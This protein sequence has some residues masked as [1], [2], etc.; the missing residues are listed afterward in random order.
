VRRSFV[1]IDGICHICDGFSSANV[2]YTLKL[3]SY[4]LIMRESRG[5]L[6]I[7][8]FYNFTYVIFGD[9]TP[10]SIYAYISGKAHSR[11]EKG[12]GMKRKQ[13][14]RRANKHR[15]PRRSKKN[16]FVEPKSVEEFFAMSEDDQELWK[17]TEQGV[18][19]VRGGASAR[20]AARKFNLDPRGF[21][22]LARPALRKLRNG[23]WAAKTHDRLLRVLVIPTRKGLREIGTRDSRQASQLGKYWTAVDRYRDTGDGSALR[24][25]KVKYIIDANGKRVRLLTDL[26]ELDRLGSAGVL[27]FETLYARAA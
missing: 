7:S 25:L 12:A 26:G 1:V 23:R 21:L 20:Q 8:C 3:Y 22:Q 27:S 14:R 17:N 16:R 24:G 5:V 2:N 9:L 4:Q 6:S 13:S 15:T 10:R 19:E 18:T 11:K